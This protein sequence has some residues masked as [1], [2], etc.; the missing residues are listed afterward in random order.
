ME[1][2]IASSQLGENMV[3]PSTDLTS[4]ISG[5]KKVAAANRNKG[6]NLQKEN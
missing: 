1:S 2:V 4:C 5:L 6:K 3:D